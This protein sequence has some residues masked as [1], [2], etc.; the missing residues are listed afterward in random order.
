MPYLLNSCSFTC[1]QKHKQVNSPPTADDTSIKCCTPKD[2]SIEQKSNE[3]TS[4]IT[5]DELLS[6]AILKKIENDEILQK[7]IN[8]SKLLR[9][10]LL[11]IYEKIPS[12]DNNSSFSVPKFLLDRISELRKYDTNNV[13]SSFVQR[14]LYLSNQEKSNT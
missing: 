14:V 9:D 12:N 1:F 8:E 6:E 10:I 13:F 3:D 5:C 7:F 11:E 2:I 4:N